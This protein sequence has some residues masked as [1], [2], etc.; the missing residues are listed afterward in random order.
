MAN[1]LKK[2]RNTLCYLSSC[3]NK[4]R[5]FLIKGSS[6]DIIKAISDAAYNIIK[7]K[8]HMPNKEKKKLV[9]YA[10]DLR[11]LATKQVTIKRKKNILSSQKG[12]G[13]LNILWNIL[14]PILLG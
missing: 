2:H 13:I 10:T 9:R 1:R 6:A 7:N 4:N 5:K 3:S 8:V 12:H 11:T 14:K